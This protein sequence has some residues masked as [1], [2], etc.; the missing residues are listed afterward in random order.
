MAKK[1]KTALKP[2]VRG[3]ATTSVPK[4]IAEPPPEP[5]LI[6]TESLAASVD[7]SAPEESN[8]ATTQ[9]GPPSAPGTFEFDPD[10]AEE[11]SLQNLVDQYQDKIE[12]EVLRTV[13]VSSTTGP[14]SGTRADRLR[15]DY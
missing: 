13:K 2:V 6:P 8:L 15:T 11:Q 12:K 3:F 1:K 14:H 7:Y 10:K 9:S 5:E 4:K